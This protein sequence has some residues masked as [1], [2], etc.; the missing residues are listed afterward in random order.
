MSMLQECGRPTDVLQSSV[1]ATELTAPLDSLLTPLFPSSS[2]PG[3][4]VMVMKGDSVY[5]SRGF[6][7]ARL[8]QPAPMT[9]STILN[10]ASA[11][12]TFTALAILKLAS[13]GKI[14]L[15]DPVSK[16]FPAFNHKV[17][18]RVTLRHVL[19]HSTGLSD[20]RPHT[21][22]QWTDFLRDH[23][24]AF[25]RRPDF[26]RY[27]RENELQKIYR[28]VDTL[29]HTPGTYFEYADAPYVLLPRVVEKVTSVPFEEWVEQ[30]IF[31]PAGLKETHYVSPEF[32]HARM[33]HAYSHAKGDRRHGVYRSNDGRWDESDYGEAEFFLTR[34]DHGI[35]TSPREFAHWVKAI[36]SGKVVPRQLLDSANVTQVHTGLRDIG[37]GLGLYTQ[38]TPGWPYKV[39]H[40]SQN[41]GFSI[42]E[43]YFPDK[44][45]FYFIMANRADW[46]RLETA[47]RLD[48]ILVDKRWIVSTK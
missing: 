46:N 28:N 40:S 26:V 18:D 5:Y 1:S 20:T 9:D 25:A 29:I 10:V 27:G 32:S 31:A 6:G 17:F 16:Y 39:F 14:S 38:T 13:E 23:R 41:G 37:Y 43:A 22:E 19:S 4:Y 34:A 42:Y 8:D 35:F 15:D 7:R 36:Y 11:S 33:A 48:S 21:E 2:D 44:D 24:T 12:K 47:Y 30:N 45:I 3:A